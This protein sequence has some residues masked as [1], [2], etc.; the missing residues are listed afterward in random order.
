MSI[1]NSIEVNKVKYFTKPDI[2]NQTVIF[3]VENPIKRDKPETLYKYYPI[4]KNS[5]DSVV[6]HY[7]FSPHPSFLNDK[8]DCSGELID[9]SNLTLDHFINRFSKELKLYTEEKVRELYNSDKKWILERTFADFNLIILF[10]KFGIISLTEDHKNI[11]MWAYYSQNSGFAI[12]YKTGLLPKDFFGPFPINYCEKL[13][14]IDFAKY[15]SPLCV[16][17]QSNIKQNLWEQE[18]EWRY[19][20]YNR[21]G[22]YHPDNSAADIKTRKFFHD[23]SAMEEI[24]LGYDFFNPKEIKY[25]LRT[26]EYDIINLSG[27]KSKGLKKLKRKLLGHV[28]KNSIPCRQ[29]IRHRYEF[30]LDAVEI[31]IEKLSSNKFKIY[32]S[33]KQISD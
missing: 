7:L 5:V 30:L 14:K 3:I 28:V 6:N 18:K 10:M 2:K 17:Y 8:Y 1:L 11:L 21:D 25:S 22:K 33:F 15:D 29:I 19:L 9:Y 16:L 31:K 4:N 12:K 32:N 26:A 13:E 20:T 23:L 27:K 24:I